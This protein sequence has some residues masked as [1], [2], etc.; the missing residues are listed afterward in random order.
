MAHD[1]LADGFGR[2]LVFSRRL[3]LAQLASHGVVYERAAT[4]GEASG[5]G[6]A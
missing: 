4:L 3:Q 1:D 5:A 6:S 2:N